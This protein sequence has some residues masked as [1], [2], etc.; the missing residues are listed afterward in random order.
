[1]HRSQLETL[2]VVTLVDRPWVGGLRVQSRAC[3]LDE[4]LD[5]WPLT[6]LTGCGASVI[7]GKA[8]DPLTTEAAEEQRDVE[9]HSLEAFQLQ[10]TNIEEF[11][12][13]FSRLQDLINRCGET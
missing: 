10:T 9:D 12:A 13:I 4:W 11:D 3:W 6:I 5:T 7:E 8:H 2:V 1:M